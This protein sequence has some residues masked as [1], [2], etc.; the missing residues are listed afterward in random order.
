MILDRRRNLCCVKNL[1]IR[2]V[3]IKLKIICTIVARVC[4]KTFKMCPR[5]GAAHWNSKHK[6]ITRQ[7]PRISSIINNSRHTF[8]RSIVS[9]RLLEFWP[10]QGR[11][12]GH[13]SFVAARWSTLGGA[14]SLYRLRSTGQRNFGTVKS[15]VS[16]FESFF[17]TR[18]KEASIGGLAGC[19]NPTRR[20]RAGEERE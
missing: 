15:T 16:S 14:Q 2:D 20:W 8:S 10:A 12:V 1:T 5:N 7:P 3:N 9:R 11:R 13:S 17:E 6:N 19:V 18:L 4:S